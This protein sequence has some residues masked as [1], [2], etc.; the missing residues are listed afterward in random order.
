VSLI[1]V[2]RETLSRVALWDLM[3]KGHGGGWWLVVGDPLSF[4]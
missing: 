2:N 1:I 3:K 4:I